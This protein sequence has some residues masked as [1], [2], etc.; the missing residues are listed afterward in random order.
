MST[1]GS[2]A[3]KMG[4][5]PGNIVQEIGWDDDTDDDLRLAIEEITGAEML[6]EDTDEVVDVVVL[7]WRD[8]DGDL[9]DGLVDALSP[10]ADNGVIW[11]LTPKANRE[12]HVEPAD[13]A[14]AARTAGLQNTSTISASAAWQ[15]TRL[16]SRRNSRR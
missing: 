15:G 8:D 14:E 4:L 9:V 2:F 11:L 13:I 10:L 6:D 7:W 12:G 1:N 3:Q 5:Q 16:V